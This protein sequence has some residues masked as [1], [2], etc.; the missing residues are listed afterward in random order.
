MHLFNRHPAKNKPRGNHKDSR[1]KPEREPACGQI[2]W[3]H[4]DRGKWSIHPQR[5]ENSSWL[6]VHPGHN[7]L[8]DA[9]S[10]YSL[11]SGIIHF[12]NSSNNG[13]VKAV[14]LE[15][16]L[17]IIPLAMSCSRIN[18]TAADL[19]PSRAAGS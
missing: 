7:A 16:G 11:P 13:A 12:V 4:I 6:S 5:F 15:L 19:L 14:F 10:A 3:Q 2:K 18:A 1:K 17:K 8:S 9:D